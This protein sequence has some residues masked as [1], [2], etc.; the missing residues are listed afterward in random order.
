MRITQKVLRHWNIS[1][2]YSLEPIPSYWGKSYVVTTDSNHHYILKEKE[3]STKATQEYGLLSCLRRQGLPVAPP[4]LTN[5]E[6]PYTEYKSRIFCLCS[7]LPGTETVDHYCEGSLERAH[8]FGLAIGRL[9][10]TLFSCS[11][12]EGF[13]EM[14]LVNHVVSWAIPIVRKNS[15]IS[16]LDCTDTWVERFRQFGATTYTLLPKQL[17][18]KDINPSNMLFKD[19]NLTGIVDFDMVTH[20]PEVFDVCYCGS[21]ILV[22]GF[23]DSKKREKWIDI[24]VSLVQG[25]ETL[26][27]L[28]KEERSSVFLVLVA[29]QLMF[30]AF[31][32]ERGQIGPAKRNTEVLKWLNANANRIRTHMPLY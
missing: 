3:D 16:G 5:S 27:Q 9:H 12:V 32:L 28:T 20:G 8:D 10:K 2:K 31:S 11:S 1:G 30:M 19:G 26:R 22:G 21:S 15:S 18:H 6:L 7:C 4:I 23:T 17:I 25:Y 24:F 14:D 13:A 29:I